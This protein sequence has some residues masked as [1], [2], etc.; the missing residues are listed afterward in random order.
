M[1]TNRDATSCMAFVHSMGVCTPCV[2]AQH[3]PTKA[4]FRDLLQDLT[5]ARCAGGCT[6]VTRW[7]DAHLW[8]SPC[9]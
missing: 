9:T 7:L 1:S 6:I 4:P 3:A 5:E 2:T 8:D